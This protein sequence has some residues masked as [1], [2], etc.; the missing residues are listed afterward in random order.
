MTQVANKWHCP[1]HLW[2]SVL[3]E[4]GGAGVREI[5]TRLKGRKRGKVST[6]R[7]HRQT[8]DSSTRLHA[9]DLAVITPQT[10]LPASTHAHTYTHAYTRRTHLLHSKNSVWLLH[11]I[12][13]SFCFYRSLLYPKRNCPVSFLE[14]QHVVNQGN[15]QHTRTWEIHAVVSYYTADRLFVFVCVCK[16]CWETWRNK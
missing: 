15:T 1:Q 9:G 4:S 14:A 7:C 12:S 8:D 13:I 5:N 3:G 16:Q 11:F 6:T 2:I 10:Y